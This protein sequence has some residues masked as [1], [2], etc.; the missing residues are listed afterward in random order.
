MLSNE[1]KGMKAFLLQVLLQRA[2]LKKRSALENLKKT[3][4]TVFSASYMSIKNLNDEKL[5]NVSNIT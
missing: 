1:I 3:F 5:I 4:W 2:T